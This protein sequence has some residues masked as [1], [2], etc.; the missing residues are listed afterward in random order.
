MILQFH[1]F[2]VVLF[3]IVSSDPDGALPLAPK[4]LSSLTGWV[5]PSDLCKEPQ[6]IY[7]VSSFSIK[8]VT[9]LKINYICIIELKI[10]YEIADNAN[11]FLFCFVN[12]HVS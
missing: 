2:L 7:A 11:N 3:N 8:Q 9:N 12:N 5:R 4:Q 1:F 6:M 10:C